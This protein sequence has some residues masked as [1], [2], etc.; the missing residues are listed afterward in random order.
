MLRCPVV[1]R[2]FSL[3]RALGFVAAMELAASSLVV[4]A[5]AENNAVS[6]TPQMGWS[7][8][9]FVRRGPTEAIIKAQALAMHQNLQSSG[10]QYVNLDDFWYLDPRV[11]VDA[12]GR[13]VPDPTKFPDGMAALGAYIHGL[14]LKFGMYS[15]LVFRLPPLIAT[16]RSKA[17]IILRKTS[18][19]FPNMRSITISGTPNKN[20][21]YQ[22]PDPLP[23]NLTAY[24]SRLLKVT[25]MVPVT[26]Y[27]VNGP[28][29]HLLGSAVYGQANTCSNGTK[30]GYI[31]NGGSVV[32]GN[33]YAAKAGTYNL[34]I[35][36]FTD[37]DRPGTISVNSAAPLTVTFPSTGSFSTLGA[38]TQPVV[39]NAGNNTITISA[40]GS[41]FGPDIDSITVEATTTQ[42]LADAAQFNGKDIAIVA[43]PEGTDGKKLTI[44]QGGHYAVTFDVSVVNAGVHSVSILLYLSGSP[45]S[46]TVKANS[47][48]AQVVN[49]PSTSG[50]PGDS[51]VVGVVNVNLELLAGSN[52]ITLHPSPARRLRTSIQSS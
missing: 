20:G 47:S 25:P 19:I 36:Y 18:P 27:L 49:F 22:I 11:T 51:T 35:L 43:S 42:Y 5:F 23:F 3:C 37:P 44:S 41:S 52:T 31:G 48:K 14:G 26:Q 28:N 1:S 9:S 40:P 29:S 16:P 32:F 50:N 21:G 10:F 39:L 15:R 45:A 34:T 12:Y 13:W 24:Q 17:P 33:V 8:W 6:Q 38:I 4:S 2:H 46:A 7:S 30:A